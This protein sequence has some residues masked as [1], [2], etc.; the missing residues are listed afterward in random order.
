MDGLIG[1]AS[2]SRCVFCFPYYQDTAQEIMLDLL[3]RKI[4]ASLQL[5]GLNV[6]SALEAVGAEQTPVLQTLEIGRAIYERLLEA[7]EHAPRHPGTA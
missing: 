1:W 6:V 7:S 2:A 5:D 4:A 3:G